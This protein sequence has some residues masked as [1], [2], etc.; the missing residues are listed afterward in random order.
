MLTKITTRSL[1]QESEANKNSIS[2]CKKNYTANEVQYKQVDLVFDDSTLASS[3]RLEQ[4][5]KECVTRAPR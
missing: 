1:Q 3:N 4:Y 2:T 5:S